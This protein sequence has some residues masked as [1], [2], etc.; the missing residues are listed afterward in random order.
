MITLVPYD[1]DWPILFKQEQQLLANA[2]S[3][4][5]VWIEH[6]GSTAIP[7]IHAKPIIDIMLG[8]DSLDIADKHLLAPIQALGYMYLRELEQQMPY[9]RFF[10]KIDIHG[11]RT[12]HIH[13]V[14]YNS[15]FWIRHI[16]F[17][18][19]LRLNPNIAK[20]YEQFKLSLAP[21]FTDTRKYAEAK[22]D[23]IKTIENQAFI[24]S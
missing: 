8:V 6:I 22:S 10:Q 11:T 3:E 13:L 14:Q 19:H 17:R 4:Y 24:S 7:E 21:H 23:F 20:K 16:R 15:E 9:R 12:H 18:D 2:T 5:H 1:K